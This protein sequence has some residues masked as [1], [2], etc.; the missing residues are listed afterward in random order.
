MKIKIEKDWA[1]KNKILKV[2]I[3]DFLKMYNYK[4]TFEGGTYTVTSGHK[5]PEA[6]EDLQVCRTALTFLPSNKTFFITL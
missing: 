2:H 1:L 6:C 4:T 5:F 3:N